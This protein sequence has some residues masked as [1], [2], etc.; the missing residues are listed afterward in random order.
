LGYQ[1]KVF[2]RAGYQWFLN[3]VTDQSQTGFSVGA[4][5]NFSD[6]ALD[7]ALVTYGNLGTTN[8]VAISYQ[9]DL[10][11]AK[12]ARQ[13]DDDDEDYGIPKPQPKSITA[14]TQIKVTSI[15]DAYAQG[16]AAYKNKNY[17][18]AALLFKKAAGMPSTEGT[19]GY[20]AQAN[21]MLGVLY[22]YHED[23]QDHLDL[24]ISYYRA[25]IHIDPNN[26]TVQKHL[27]ELETN[28]PSR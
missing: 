3:P 5:L 12:R 8:Q 10:P 11:K 28:E 4:G 27:N 14:A 16:I 17:E 25:A 18:L 9:F 2:L 26:A 24:A 19:K 15:Q 23:N 13:E 20:L 1:K 22:E 7:Y 21:V 6:V